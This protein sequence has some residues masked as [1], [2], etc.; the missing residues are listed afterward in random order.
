MRRCTNHSAAVSP[1]VDV[2]AL[3]CTRI[4]VLAGRQEELRQAT[5]RRPTPELHRSS[6]TADTLRVQLH[7]RSTLLRLVRHITATA[8]ATAA[9]AILEDSRIHMSYNS[10]RARTSRREVATQSTLHLLVRHQERREME[11]SGDNDH[12]GSVAGRVTA[13]DALHW[14]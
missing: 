2:V 9:R 1:L 3:A 6:T 10:Q 13:T 14:I 11:S 8:T 7:L 12:E 4:A 5:R